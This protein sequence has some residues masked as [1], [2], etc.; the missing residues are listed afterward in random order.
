MTSTTRPMVLVSA[1]LRSRDGHPGFWIDRKYLDAVRLAGAEPWIV[2][3]ASRDDISALLDRADGVLLTGSPS[4]VEPHHYGEALL[5]P[6]QPTD[7]LRDAWTLPLVR[8][9]IARDV[10]LFGI[11]RGL[12][13]VN[14]ALGGS[15]R[16][17][18]PP[19]GLAHH[20][21]GDST[22][23]IYAPAHRVDVVP[24]G[25]LQELLDG[26]VS[27]DV[28]SIHVQGIARLAPGLRVEAHAPD[29][30]VEAFSGA[31]LPGF[32]L[33]VQWHP[34]WQAAES[35]VSR[36]LLHAFGEACRRRRASR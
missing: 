29:G 6:T 21:E 1:C 8:D 17:A 33:A 10:P 2:A 34:E 25:L 15:L 11:C 22:E 18:L 36:R 28:N 30:V 26:K 32:V 35:D 13:E 9:A 16:Q 4:N 23:L 20:A 14:V 5:D 31:A 19:D 3:D 24:G 7:P 27:F 12:Q